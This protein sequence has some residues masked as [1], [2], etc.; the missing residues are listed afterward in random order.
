[1]TM[2]Q[3]PSMRL[4][5]IDAF[6]GL[7]VAAM[8]LVNNAGDWSHVYSWLE[9]AQW[10][11]CTPADFVFPF[12]LLIVGVSLELA[13]AAKLGKM[14]ALHLLTSAWWR[15]GKIILLGLALHLI[16]MM[17]IPDRQFR[18]F[19]VLQRIGLCFFLASTALI[20][21]RSTL[22]LVILSCGILL[23][24]WLLLAST[25][26]Y[27]ADLNLVDRIDTLVLG[28]LAYQF[29]PV[30]FLAHE[31]EGLLSTLPATVNVLLGIV[32]ARLLRAKQ[33]LKLILAGLVLIALAWIWSDVMPW[34]KQLWTS[35]F[36]CWTCG[37]G[38]VVIAV[39]HYLIDQK[40][41][42]ALGQSFGVNA[43][44]A[45]AGAWVA[46]CIIAA[47]NAMPFIYPQWLVAAIV[48]RSSEAFASFLFAVMFTLCFGAL[49][50]GLRRRGWRFSI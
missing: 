13:L 1:M 9:H 36:V 50:Y 15:A 44:L 24:Y 47:T 26:T 41:L 38:F 46:T 48:K 19:G 8:L 2:P 3:L 5:S 27:Q 6:R 20:F 11:G 10:H 7:T 43:I 21:L 25:G 49:M 22:A 34:N 39:L 23:G 40:G 30:T 32:A 17:L 29:D 16:A 35:S 28:P 18:L 42:P 33:V 45:Y 4:N 37:W 31:P 14:P 12:F